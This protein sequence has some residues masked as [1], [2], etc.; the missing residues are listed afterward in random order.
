MGT[1]FDVWDGHQTWFWSLIG[2]H[3]NS[4]A[5]GAA[6]TEDEAVREACQSIE[7]TGRDVFIA[8]QLHH[9]DSSTEARQRPVSPE[10]ASAPSR[11]TRT[12]SWPRLLRP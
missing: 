4:G 3:R 11:S 7:E 8:A 1:G 2:P 10:T 6:A 9:K 5:I 12:S